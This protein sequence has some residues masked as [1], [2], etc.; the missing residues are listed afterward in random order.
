MPSLLPGPLERIFHLLSQSIGRFT[1]KIIV[2]VLLIGIVGAMAVSIGGYW[3]GSADTVVAAPTPTA[4]ASDAWTAEQYVEQIAYFDPAAMADIRDAQS[5][6]K[7]MRARELVLMTARH[8]YL[9]TPEPQ[10]AYETADQF[11]ETVALDPQLFI[12]AID[13]NRVPAARRATLDKLGRRNWQAIK[14]MFTVERDAVGELDQ[15]SAGALEAGQYR[16]ALHDIW[17]NRMD[18]LVEMCRSFRTR[19]VEA[20]VFFASEE[21]LLAALFVNWERAWKY[22]SKVSR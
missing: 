14:R 11:V 1:L 22:T 6:G 12:D 3:S 16:Q 18:T 4:T 7:A 8:F 9:L 10:A 2:T 15:Y 21:H 17:Q 20:R 5:A 19:D 13:A